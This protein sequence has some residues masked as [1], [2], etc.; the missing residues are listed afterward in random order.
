MYERAALSADKPSLKLV[1]DDPPPLGV[2]LY[3]VS[4]HGIGILGDYHPEWG[5]VAWSELPKL[6]PEQKRRLLALEAAKCDPTIPAS[7]LG[8]KPEGACTEGAD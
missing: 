7:Q 8:W 3:L 5:I 6:S 2:K 1:C 4:T